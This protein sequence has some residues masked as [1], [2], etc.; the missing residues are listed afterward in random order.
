VTDEAKIPVADSGELDRVFRGLESYW[1]GGSASAPYSEKTLE[2]AY[3]PAFMGSM[4]D[5]DAVGARVDD[6]GDRL[7]VFLKA[8]AGRIVRA[9]FLADGC[10]VSV[11]CG[12]AAVQL[13]TG[14]TVAEARAVTAEAIG[15]FLGGLPES[16][17]HSAED[18]VL[19]LRDGLDRLESFKRD[20]E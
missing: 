17:G 13:A 6:C 15:G 1:M 8:E 3:D 10:A 16:A 4:E 9:S 5:A 7:E 2:L 12:S 14:R 11:A 20:A 18:W 19:A